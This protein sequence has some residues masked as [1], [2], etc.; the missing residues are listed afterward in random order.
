MMESTS[1]EE[2]EIP[3]EVEAQLDPPHALAGMID[4]VEVD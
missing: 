4:L 3:S 2:P 1:S